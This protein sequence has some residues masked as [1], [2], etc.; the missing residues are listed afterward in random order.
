M[1]KNCLIKIK[2]RLLYLINSNNYKMKTK[3]NGILTLLL[4]FIVQITFAQEKTISGTVSDETG[5]LPGVSVMKKGT[6]SGTETD[7]D[8]NYTILAKEGDVLIFSFIGMKTKEQIVGV[9]NNIT[10]EMDSDNLLDEVVVVAYGT[11]ARRATTGSIT[12]VKGDVIENIPVANIAESLQGQSTGLLSVSSSGQ[13]G[14]NSAVRI[15][16][17]AS[18]NGNLE[19]LYI[20]DGIAI[21]AEAPSDL[22][23]G[24]LDSGLRDPLSNLNPADI[25]S[26]TILKDASS[27]SIYGARAANGIIMITTKRGKEGKA[28]FEFATQVGVS[29]RAVNKYKSLNASEYIELHREADIN[30]GFTPSEALARNPDTDVDTNWGDY[31]YRDWKALTK[32]YNFS[33]SG[34]NDKI[35]YRSSLGYLNQDGIAVG[36]G[37]ERYNLGLNVNAKT[38]DKSRIGTSVSLSR[39]KQATSLADAA[40]FASPIVATYLFNPTDEPY[41]EDGTPNP[42]NSVTGGTSFIQDAYYD[43]ESS[44]TDRI[45]TSIYGELDL[46]EDFTFR[47]QFG[48]DKSFFNFRSYSNPLNTSSPAGGGASRTYQ[49]FTN[50]TFTNTLRWDKIFGDHK[51][52]ILLGTEI[53]RE[54]IDAFGIDVEEFPN[55]ILQVVGAGATV[56]NHY[57]ET[58]DSSLESYFFNTNYEYNDKYNLNATVRRDAS[59]RFGSENKWGT[60]WSVGANWVISSEEF[61]ASSNWIDLLKIK[62]SYGIQ[63]NIISSRYDAITETLNDTY[64]G[65]S[66]TFLSSTLGNP[67]LKWEEQKM[68]NVGLEFGLFNNRLSGEFA[69]FNRLTG[70]LIFDQ[71]F[72]PSSGF[73]VS[74]VNVGEF[75]NSG[76]ELDLSYDIISN[77]NLTWNVGVN[78]T[79]IDNEVTKLDP[80]TEGADGTKIR[81]VGEDWQTFYLQ[82]WA[83]VDPA[84]GAPM[85][86]DENDNITFNYADA[87][88][89]KVGSANADYFGAFS[90][91]VKYKNFDFN[92]N[93]TFQEGNK[94]YNNTSRITNSDGAFS[95]F[96]QS[97]EQLDRWQ[98][99]GDISANPIRITGNGSQSNQQ[100]TRW[101]ED[102]SY[103]RLRNVALGYSIP[104]DALKSTM[105]TKARV[106]LQGSN[107]L[108]FT[109]FNGDPEQALNGTSFFVYPNAQTFTLGIN[110][111]F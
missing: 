71:T 75:R 81:E 78:V 74:S 35:N 104:N 72:E 47:T 111:S 92:A 33:V 64:N 62:S 88:R 70:D 23:A 20:I 109:N 28:K 56:S 107:L 27:T 22:G 54:S 55:G 48:F 12:T 24:G 65:A 69:Y 30:A 11:K 77:K 39:T 108:T 9:S 3:F 95:G 82:R 36:S 90:T 17:N 57:S 93:F 7:F 106:Y 94:I 61:L 84:T 87:S 96:N 26:V 89:E 44:I 14:A 53:N 2:L 68:F 103:I 110:V 31:A 60:F 37:I 63:G 32:R 91:R 76:F 8:G 18:V 100:S 15:R 66:A 80:G 105:F 50:Y 73:L 38:S 21:S 5:P 51:L 43:N 86:L 13:P 59:S 99:P 46:F 34:G 25:E 58:E 1:L 102:G 19:P 67:E 97:R 6:S 29:A 45:I 42:N 52:D 4:A 83:G 85:W 10:F 16:G 79:K 41:L 40:Y 101:L 98:E 49:D